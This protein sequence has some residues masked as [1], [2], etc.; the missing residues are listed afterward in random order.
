MQTPRTLGI[1]DFHFYLQLVSVFSSKRICIS[2]IHILLYIKIIISRQ[3]PV[4]DVWTST[5]NANSHSLWSLR[6]WWGNTQIFPY[7]QR[8]H[9]QRIAQTNASRFWSG[10]VEKNTHTHKHL[11]TSKR[12]MCSVPGNGAHKLYLEE[13]NQK[14]IKSKPSDRYQDHTHTHTHTH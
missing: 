1:V 5:L 4:T 13:L 10:K 9:K 2:W 6:F 8:R 11:H 12:W 14:K 7:T 3:R